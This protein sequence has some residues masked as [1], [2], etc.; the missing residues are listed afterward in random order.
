M[1]KHYPHKKIIAILPAY[2]AG[3]TLKKTYHDIPLGWVDDIILVDD[4]STDNTIEVAQK[5]GIKTF[6]HEINKGYG[7]NQKT[8]YQQSLNMGADIIIMIHPDHQYDPTLIPRLLEPII[9]GE[10]DAAFGSR[11]L[12]SGE[13]LKGGMP[14]WK[15]L[16]NKLLTI[17]ENAIL[18]LNL[19]EYHSGFRAY[20]ADVFKNINYHENSNNFVFDT[21]IIVQIK[22]HNFSIK[23]V[24]IPTRYFK[25]ASSVGIRQG[26][27]YGLS[28]IVVMFQYLLHGLGFVKYHK[29]R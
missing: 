2:N 27:I 19:S 9:N 3:K 1:S 5:L 26:I 23:E 21:E 6:K 8:C 4:G 29:F 15:Y 12:I 28:I 20:S 13:A 10:C 24:P 14:Y 25:D 7:A 18:R 11:M 16:A 22:I 17:I